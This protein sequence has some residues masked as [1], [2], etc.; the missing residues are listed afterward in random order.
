MKNLINLFEDSVFLVV[1]C[2]HV[3]CILHFQ[4]A[5]SKVNVQT[6]TKSSPTCMGISTIET[7]VLSLLIVA[8]PNVTALYADTLL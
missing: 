2:Y 3:M 7:S 1:I 6:V 4:S 5:T 8:C